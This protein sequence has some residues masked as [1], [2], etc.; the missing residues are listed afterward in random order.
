VI[1]VAESLPT[2]D[3][4]RQAAAFRAEVRTFLRKSEEA[5]RRNGLTP[6]RYLLLLMIK[7]AA[8]G[9]ERSTV[10]DLCRVLKLGQSTVT[11]L[12]GRA[13]DVGLLERAGDAS[14]GRVAH[15]Y[16]TDEGEHRVNNVVVELRGDRERLVAMFSEPSG[17]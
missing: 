16:L 1:P 7:G 4:F 15:L 10:T 13:H 6:Q 12:V 3:E 2:P 14:D 8:D 11:E 17:A 5:A 9:S